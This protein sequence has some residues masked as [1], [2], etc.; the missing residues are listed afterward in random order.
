VT[1]PNLTLTQLV[2]YWLRNAHFNL[3][4]RFYGVIKAKNGR[5]TIADVRESSWAFEI[6]LIS[7]DRVEIAHRHGHKE[8]TFWAADPEF[9]PKLEK[10]LTWRRNHFEQR[11]PHVS[12]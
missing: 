2:E 9:F 10:Y 8:I 11:T 6:G 5:N 4:P 1:D 7:P 3:F 12:S